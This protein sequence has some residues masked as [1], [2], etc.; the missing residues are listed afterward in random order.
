[1]K[2]QSLRQHRGFTLVELLI[3]IAI[4]MVLA[5]LGFAGVQ[6]AMK[7]AKTV[8]SLNIATNVAQGIQNFYDEY[9]SLPSTSATASEI[10][11]NSGEGVT[12]LRVLLGQE[13][14][15]TSAINTKSIRYLDIKAAKG[16]KAGLDY[17]TSG[18]TVNG[19]YDAWGEPFYVVFDDDYNDEIP[20]PIRFSTTEPAIIR[21]A[22]AIV[23]SKGADRKKNTKDDVK[24]F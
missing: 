6:T 1:M 7:R 12:L 2:I 11:T 19:L 3:V 8:Q 16:K 4:I 20:N 14:S 10:D 24:S 21:G 15:G 18:S 5:S 23:Y 17:G 22:K 9:G 13:G